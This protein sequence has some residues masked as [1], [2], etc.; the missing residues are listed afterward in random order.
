MLK[1]D[2]KLIVEFHYAKNILSKMQFDYIYHEH[3]YYF[4]IKTL[5][6]YLKK[7]NLF[8]N[9]VVESKISGGSLV[10]TFSYKNNQSKKLKKMINIEN[11]HRI[12]SYNKIKTVNQKLFKYKRDFKKLLHRNKNYKIAGYGSSARSNTLINFLEFS[13]DNLDC[14]FDKNTLKHNK[15]T[16]GK[17]LKILKPIKKEIIKFDIIIIFAWNFYDEIKNYLKNIGFKGRIVKTL[18]KLKIEK[19]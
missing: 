12:N 6:E 5:S 19:I 18:P 9:D 2:G 13:E 4:T 16:P 1:K 17:N 3:T 7:Y 11:K 8:A 10:L 15:F 14:I